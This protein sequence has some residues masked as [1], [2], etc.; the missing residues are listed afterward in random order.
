MLELLIS[1]I[2]AT[3][4]WYL[5]F[6]LKALNFWWGMTAAAGLLAIWSIYRAGDYRSRLFRFDLRQFLWGVFSALALYFIF[7]IG[8]FI[9]TRIFPLAAGQIAAVYANRADL[10]SYKIALLL[11]FWIGPAEEIFWR[12]MVQRTLSSYFGKNTG[13]I[14]GAIIYSA[15]HLWAANLMLC[16]AALICGLFWGH[17]YKKF[18]SLWPGIISHV[19]WDLLIF[20]IFPL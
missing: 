5:I 1:L 14:L 10:E 9:S 11:F 17:L 18:G 15:V 7:W 13:W 2:F 6:G 16:G 8:N 4:S 20:L 19:I 12:G 3:F